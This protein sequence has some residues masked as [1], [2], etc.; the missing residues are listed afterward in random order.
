M[1]KSGGKTMN[2][3]EAIRLSKHAEK[4]GANAISAIPPLFFYYSNEDIYNYYKSLA[5][6]TNLPFIIYNHSAA[7]GGMSAEAVAK[8]FEIENITGVKWTINNYS[9]LMKLKD[10]TNGELNIINGPDDMLVLGLVAGA[11]AGIGTTYNVLLPQFLEIYKSFREGNIARAREIQVQINRVIACIVRHDAIPAVKY[12]CS[13]LGF[14]SGDA[15]YP[16]KKLKDSDY[17]A[18]KKELED[19]GWPSFSKN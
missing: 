12:M 8:L 6:S 2:F 5:S 9:E 1:K 10:L 14:P 15:T 17:A 11:D 13:M 7:N 19:L 4:A 16:M 3:D 18:L